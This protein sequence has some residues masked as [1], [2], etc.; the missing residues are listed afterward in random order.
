MALKVF[1]YTLPDKTT[2]PEAYLRVQ[3]IVTANEEHEF[4]EPVGNTEDLR[5]SW[6]NNLVTRANIYVW[7]DELCRQNR[8]SP[9]HWFAIDVPLQLT[10]TENIYQQA[11]RAL[12]H[13]YEQI[14]NC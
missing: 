6:V 2:L 8:V 13:R 5:V 9:V 11:Y 3:S 7:A 14:E 10:S 1:N 4:L 12:G